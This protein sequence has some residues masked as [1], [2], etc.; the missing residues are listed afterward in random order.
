MVDLDQFVTKDVIPINEKEVGALP[1][2]AMKLPAAPIAHAVAQY[3]IVSDRFTL[4][5]D[6]E[7]FVKRILGG[8]CY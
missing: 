8:L 4:F 2:M 5:D 6:L 7:L 3:M 1:V